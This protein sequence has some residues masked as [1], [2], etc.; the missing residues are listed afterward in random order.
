MKLHLFPPS[1]NARKVLLVKH[2]L[3]LE[4]EV[5]VVDLQA[6][7]QRAP[8]FVDR[9]PNGLMPVLEDDDGFVL[10]ES[11]AILQHLCTRVPGQTLWP[12][13]DREQADV[14]RWLFWQTAHWGPACGG[15]TFERMTKHFLELGA[16]DEKRV[17]ECLANFAKY[18]GVLD[19]HLA[20]REWVTGELSLADFA[21]GSMLTYRGPA[22][23]PVE[24]HPNVNAWFE[25][26]RSIPAWEATRPGIPGA[27]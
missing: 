26:L 19:G 1:P 13:D 15:L 27:A 17:A 6:G 21:I 9:N 3:G 22:S 8:E 2:H 11:N 10:W 16:P 23:I 20:D 12:R 25:R 4:C 24:D 14:L 18:A 5:V 7:D